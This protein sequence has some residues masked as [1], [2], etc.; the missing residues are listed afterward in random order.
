M[1][2]TVLKVREGLAGIAYV[3]VVYGDGRGGTFGV[4]SG[5]DIVKT[6]EKH[7]K[8]IVKWDEEGSK[9]VRYAKQFEGKEFE[10]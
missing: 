6:A 5:D 1:K 7:Y 8:H 4:G 9:A 10:F 2:F 3:D